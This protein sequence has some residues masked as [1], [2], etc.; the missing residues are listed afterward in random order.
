MSHRLKKPLRTT[1]NLG[2]DMRRV[3]DWRVF[4]IL[5]WYVLVILAVVFTMCRRGC[6]AAPD[7]KP[8]SAVHFPA[9]TG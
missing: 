9:F 2:G 8:E 6:G 1:I 4:A 3:I 5:A 7:P